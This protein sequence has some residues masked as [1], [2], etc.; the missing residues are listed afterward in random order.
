MLKVAAAVM[1]EMLD[2]PSVGICPN[3]ATD[4]SKIWGRPPC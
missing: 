2:F 4:W 1:N 3:L